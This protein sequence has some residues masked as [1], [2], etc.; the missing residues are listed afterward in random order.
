MPDGKKALQRNICSK[1]TSEHVQIQ[2]QS[3]KYAGQM[4]TELGTSTLAPPNQ[5]FALIEGIQACLLFTGVRPIHGRLLAIGRVQG[6]CDKSGG[7]LAC[8]FVALCLCCKN[9][10]SKSNKASMSLPANTSTYLIIC[11]GE[12]KPCNYRNVAETLVSRA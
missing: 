2:T 6:A 5:K 4:T 10:V 9:A 11:E 8:A 7:H 3:N 12:Q 1:S